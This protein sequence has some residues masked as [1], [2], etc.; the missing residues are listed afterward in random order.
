MGT[1]SN[2]TFANIFLFA[3]LGTSAISLPFEFDYLLPKSEVKYTYSEQ[4]CNWDNSSSI[5]TSEYNLINED[6]EN[7]NTIISFSKK[8]LEQSKDLENEYAEIVNRNFWDLI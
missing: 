1:N 7:M 3:T 5:L 4:L 6:S 8:L 2:N